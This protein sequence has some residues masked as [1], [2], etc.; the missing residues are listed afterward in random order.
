MSLFAPRLALDSVRSVSRE[1]DERRLGAVLGDEV[2]E[3][4]A[5][6]VSDP[7]ELNVGEHRSVPVSAQLRA[8][9]VEPGGAVD[10]KLQFG[11]KIAKRRQDRLLVVDD[12]NSPQEPFLMLGKL[13]LRIRGCKVRARS[14]PAWQRGSIS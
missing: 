12:E 11:E 4:E 10:L 8:R 3:I 1:N 9:L 13:P 5:V 14:A 7:R 2:G 6:R